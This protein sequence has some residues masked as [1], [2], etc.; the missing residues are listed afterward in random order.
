MGGPHA[1]KVSK[2][3]LIQVGENGDFK[4]G[5]KLT[6]RGREHLIKCG[7]AEI[8][9]KKDGTITIKGKDIS[10]DDKG[11]ITD[12]GLRQDHDEG[13]RAGSTRTEDERWTAVCDGSTAW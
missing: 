7:S 9:M 12:Q 2:D 11:K 5:K 6:D 13:L 8:A 1:L 3:S 4:V 10:V